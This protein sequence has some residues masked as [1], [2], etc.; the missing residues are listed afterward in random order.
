M[1]RKKAEELGVTPMGSVRSYASAGVPPRIMGIGPVPATQKVLAKSGLS[2]DEIDLIEANEAFAAQSLAVGRELRLGLGARQRQRRRNRP[3]PPDRRQRHAHPGDAAPRDEAPR[4]PS[5]ASPRSASAAARASRWWSR[6]RPRPIRHS[7]RNRRRPRSLSPLA[8]RRPQRPFRLSTLRDSGARS[9]PWR[10]PARHRSPPAARPNQRRHLARRPRAPRAAD[11]RR[12]P[13]RHSPLWV[14]AGADL[15]AGEPALSEFID[16]VRQA[17]VKLGPHERAHVPLPI[18]APPAKVVRQRKR[19]LGD[20]RPEPALG[21]LHGARARHLRPGL[22]ASAPPAGVRRAPG[23]AAGR[24]C[25]AQSRAGGGSD[26]RDRDGRFVD[27][28]AGRS[29]RRVTIVGVPPAE[30]RGR[31]AVAVRRNLRRILGDAAPALLESDAEL[32]A[33]VLLGYYARMEEEGRVDRDARVLAGAI[34]RVG[35][36]LLGGGWAGQ[37]ADPGAA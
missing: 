37:A 10:R 9:P 19:R 12:R 1:S 15:P 13:R 27:C 11:R 17:A 14:P 4:T 7:A 34:Q 29:A 21:A 30:T 16:H 31:R 18:T 28:P 6:A 8:E 24:G 5:A 3:R 23:G 26:C 33:L 2:L 20:G 22:D 32:K 25:R 35:V 36:R